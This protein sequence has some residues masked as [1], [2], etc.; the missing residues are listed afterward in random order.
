MPSQSQLLARGTEMK[1]I[2][3]IFR[4][5]LG[6]VFGSASALALSPAFAAFSG[7]EPG[8]ATGVAFWV[9]IIACIALLFF[10]PTI[11]RAFGRG[12]L[13][14][15]ASTFA[16]PISVLLLSGRVASDTM[17]TAVTES[18]R[19]G[20]AL[21]AGVAGTIMTG[22]AGFIGFFLGT[23]FLIIGLVLALGG[24]REV[25]VTNYPGYGAPNPQ[26][27]PETQRQPMI[28]ATPRPAL[29]ANAPD[30]R[31]EPKL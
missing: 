26:G 14:L 13:M 20:A 21:G 27:F 8:A 9:F 5:F 23:I 16:L 3:A 30:Q 15:G 17:A 6:V 24:R 19:A 7:S 2:K 31:I 22:A 10:A 4:I 29:S 18:E 11:R 1:V 12:F 25:V 28:D